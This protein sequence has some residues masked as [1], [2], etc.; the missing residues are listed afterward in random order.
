[1]AQQYRTSITPVRDAL[2]MLSQGGLVTI[3]PRSGY[4]VTHTT[5]KQLRD[6]LDLREILELA[7]IERAAPRITDDELAQ[8][9]KVHAG[10]SGDDEE[11]YER[12]TDENRR[13]HTMLAEASGNQELAVLIGSLM[14]R[15]A[16][17]MVLCQAGKT[18]QQSHSRLTSAL[19][20]RDARVA[21]QVLLDELLRSREILMERV[22]QEEASMWQLV[23]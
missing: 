10:Y 2:Q 21:R 16:R 17:F 5:L 18:L 15:L 3:K 1:M 22:M 4:Y 20:T 8:L 23:S 19:R 7:C 11:S 14:D 12:Y 13:F 6:L 9:E